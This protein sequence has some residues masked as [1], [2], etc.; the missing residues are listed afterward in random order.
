VVDELN[1]KAVNDELRRLTLL[2]WLFT[3]AGGSGN[4]NISVGDLFAERAEADAE[5]LADDL[6]ALN[7]RGW[8]SLVATMGD[9]R[10][11]G[12]FLNADAAAV[13]REMREKRGDLIGRTTSLRDRLLRWLY[14]RQA[15][16]NGAPTTSDF[17]GSLE[18][19][20]FGSI[21]QPEELWRATVWLK[22]HDFIRGSGSSQLSGG[23]VRPIITSKGQTVVESGRSVNEIAGA[24]LAA[25]S[26]IAITGNN[27][28]VQSASP[29]ATQSVTM[30]ISSDD[31]TQTI[32]LAKA[33]EEALPVLGLPAEARGLPDELRVAAAQ[34]DPSFMQRVLAQVQTTIAEKSGTAIGSAMLTGFAALF[35]RYGIHLPVQP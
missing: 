6:R 26:T 33:L 14:T 19:I 1:A 32:Q 18:C 8:A 11:H 29:D 31:R 27:N 3:S 10:P 4:R 21:Y 28:V 2:D 24:A 30:S 34:E 15:E 25:S 35:E 17:F 7:A 12:V 16:I 13:A 23:I 20:Y 5:I 22:D 9:R